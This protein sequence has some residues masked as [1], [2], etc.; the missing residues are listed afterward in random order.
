MVY[1]TPMAENNETTNLELISTDDLIV[2]V[3]RRC[4][5]LIVIRNSQK[6][7]HTDDIY[8]KTPEG[9]LSR[10]D[11]KFDL[12]HATDMLQAAHRQM[13]VVYLSKGNDD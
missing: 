10:G 9:P 6:S 5:E 3:S 12:I 8:V 7:E 11:K 1:S 13:T 2:E 4:S